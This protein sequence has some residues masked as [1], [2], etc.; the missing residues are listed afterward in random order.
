MPVFFPTAPVIPSREVLQAFPVTC[1]FAN[2]QQVRNGRRLSANK[3]WSPKN[4]KGTAAH[5]AFRCPSVRVTPGRLGTAPGGWNSEPNSYGL[6]AGGWTYR[7]QLEF[8]ASTRG[9]NPRPVFSESFRGRLGEFPVQKALPPEAQGR[10]RS[11]VR[12]LDLAFETLAGIGTNNRTALRHEPIREC[13]RKIG[14]KAEL[15]PCWRGLACRDGLSGG[16]PRRLS[17]G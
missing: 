8:L 14:P 5:V 2:R 15:G 17:P 12:A 11:S 3:R 10:P 1:I 16:E 7:G 4:T 9:G 6:G 13:D